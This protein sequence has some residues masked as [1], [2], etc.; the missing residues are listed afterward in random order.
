MDYQ[1]KYLKY[2]FKYSN[3]LNQYGGYN[4]GITK[5]YYR[6]LFNKYRKAFK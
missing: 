6:T 1:K 2:K 4:G 5:E 3:L